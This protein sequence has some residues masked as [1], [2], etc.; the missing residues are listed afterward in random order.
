LYEDRT[1]RVFTDWTYVVR[2][3]IIIVT[4]CQRDTQC[5][6][7]HEVWEPFFFLGQPKF[8]LH[9]GATRRSIMS[10]TKRVGT[11]VALVGAGILIG[12]YLSN[13]NGDLPTAKTA[14]AA[15]GVV[16]SPT[17]PAPDRYV[18]YP[19]TEE[20]KKDEIRVIC[21]GSGLPAARRGQA[22]TCWLI[23]C[24]NG[25]K[26]LFDIGTGSMANIA[27]HADAGTDAKILQSATAARLARQWRLSH[28]A[29]CVR[30]GDEHGQ[31][32]VRGGLPLL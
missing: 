32:A 6:L 14:Q 3:C 9:A 15:G 27:M 18:Y 19:G 25:E 4:A 10:K 7:L 21:C 5:A 13:Q 12:V 30:Q 31:T 1:K 8:E 23:E 28:I 17:K 2:R 26:I 24:G 11:S 22:A 16:K 29:A 20:L